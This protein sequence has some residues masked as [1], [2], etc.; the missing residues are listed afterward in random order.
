MWNKRSLPAQ[1]Q[2]CDTHT[3]RDSRIVNKQVV[4]IIIFKQ[5]RMDGSTGCFNAGSTECIKLC[6]TTWTVFQTSDMFFIIFISIDLL[7]IQYE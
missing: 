3:H 7:I 4:Q 2:L 5:N 6:K 1:H